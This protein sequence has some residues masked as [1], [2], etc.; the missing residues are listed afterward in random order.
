MFKICPGKV[1]RVTH[2]TQPEAVIDKSLRAL[3]HVKL[4]G[5][6]RIIRKLICYLPEDPAAYPGPER[7]GI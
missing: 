4:R 5:Y 3:C 7:D 2:L 6:V 1:I